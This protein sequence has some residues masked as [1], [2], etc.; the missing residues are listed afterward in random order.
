M[1]MPLGNSARFDVGGLEATAVALGVVP[2]NDNGEK[3]LPW[4]FWDELDL[5]QRLL[6]CRMYAGG[7]M[8]TAISRTGTHHN[9]VDDAI[10]QAKMYLGAGMYLA[11]MYLGAGMCLA[12]KREL[13]DEVKQKNW[14]M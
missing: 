6:D 10:H 9:A 1:L 2:K 11:K 12:G 13:L 5:R 7:N 4:K 14:G 3:Q 8:K